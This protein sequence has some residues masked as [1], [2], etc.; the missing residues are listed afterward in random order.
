MTTMRKRH[1]AAFK[2]KIVQELLK[3]EKSVTEAGDRARRPSQSI[4]RLETD[5]SRR[6]PF[7][8]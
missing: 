4:A 3:E 7:A 6:P 2:A 8:L 5:R 1:S